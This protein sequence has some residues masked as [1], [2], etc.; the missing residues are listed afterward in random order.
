M[1]SSARSRWRR[2]SAMTAITSSWVVTSR[3]VVIS[4]ASRMRRVH[5]EG[6]RDHD[7]LQQPARQFGG[8]LAQAAAGSGM[9]TS[10]SSAIARCSAASGFSPA[11]VIERLGHEVADGAQ[12]VEVGAGGLEDHADAACADLAQPT[13]RESRDVLAVDADGAADREAPPGSSPA[14]ARTE[15][16]LPEPDSPTSPRASPARHLERAVVH[17]R[18]NGS[19]G[20]GRVRPRRGRVRGRVRSSVASL[21]PRRHAGAEDVHSEHRDDH[22]RGREHRLLR[23]ARQQRGLTTRRS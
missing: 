14:T 5:R 12:R 15:R 16:V 9:P 20:A 13:R 23:R 10:S 22:Q 19:V 2:R 6:R 21:G 11:T 17:E 1:N 7:P 3:A 4:S 8:P 18:A